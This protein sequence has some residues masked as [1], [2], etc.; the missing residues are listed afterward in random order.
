MPPRASRMEAGVVP[1]T[2]QQLVILLLF[3]LPGIVYQAVRDHLQ[4]PLPSEQ[5]TGNRVLRAIAVSVALDAVYVTVAGPQLLR[6]VSGSQRSGLAGLR[7]NPRVAGMV[8]LLVLVAVPAAV[9]IGEAVA[10]RRGR[11]ARYEPTP[12]AWDHLFKDL[13]GR[14]LRIRLTDGTWVGGWYGKGSNASAF[15]Q[16]RDLFL[17]VQYSMRHD[18][19]F[20]PRVDGTGGVYVAGTDISFLEILSPPK[21]PAPAGADVKEG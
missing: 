21:E 15:P 5:D 13:G 6:L 14:F 1:S 18:G 16:P 3:A 17:D 7:E 10:R 8:G 2:V 12:S 19:R 20:G 11:A 4:G 9:A